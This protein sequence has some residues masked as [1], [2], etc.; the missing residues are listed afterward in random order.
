MY[1]NLNDKTGMNYKLIV[2]HFNDPVLY[3][4]STSEDYAYV[5]FAYHYIRFSIPGK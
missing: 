5:K 4:I 1:L 2:I 3:I